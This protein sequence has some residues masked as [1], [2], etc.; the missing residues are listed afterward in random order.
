MASSG[1]RHGH[2]HHEHDSDSDEELQRVEHKAPMEQL[3][4]V[5]KHSPLYGALE[6]AIAVVELIGTSFFTHLMI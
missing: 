3:K 6:C 2:A 5:I 1:P 4:K